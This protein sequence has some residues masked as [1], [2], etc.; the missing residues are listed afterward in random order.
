MFDETQL[1]VGGFERGRKR[2]CVLAAFGQVTQKLADG[3]VQDAD[4]FRTLAVLRRYTA[5]HCASV[6]ADPNDA[7]SLYLDDT[8]TDLWPCIVA[9]CRRQT[10]IQ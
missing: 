9:V 8:T 10:S 7:T 2:Q 3:S 1:Y 5:A 4:I 6:V